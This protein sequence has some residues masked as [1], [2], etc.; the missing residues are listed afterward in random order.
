MSGRLITYDANQDN[1]DTPAFRVQW[2]FDNKAFLPK[3]QKL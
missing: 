1:F 3:A 2:C